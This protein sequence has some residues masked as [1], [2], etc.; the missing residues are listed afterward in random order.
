MRQMT[1]RPETE[2]VAVLSPCRELFS[3][4]LFNRS[5]NYGTPE[6]I[7]ARSVGI[8]V[9]TSPPSIIFISWILGGTTAKNQKN[10]SCYHGVHEPVDTWATHMPL[11]V[12]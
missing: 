12:R 7:V 1:R 11:L 5:E 6:I 2:R 8:L 4:V 10:S 9:I 3:H